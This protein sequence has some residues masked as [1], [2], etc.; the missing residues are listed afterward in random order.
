MAYDLEEQ[1]Q[2]DAFKR[3]WDK[4]GNM[5]LVAVGV[6][7]VAFAATQFWK[8]HRNQQALEASTFYQQLLDTP[9]QDHKAIQSLSS[10][11]MDNYAGTPYAGRAAVAAAKANYEA[12]DGKSAKSQLEWAIAN[13]KESAVR[14]IARLQLAAIQ[15]DEKAYAPALK[16]L[17]AKDNAGFEGLFADLRGDV[18]VAQGKKADAKQAYQQALAHLEAQ[19]A[20]HQYVAHKLEALGS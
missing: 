12:K 8:H 17:E 20:Y 4:N 15:L 1:E 9:A 16:T 18:L 14:S 7:I 13:A 6:L 3:W 19:G 11:L 10:Q 2:L 5:V